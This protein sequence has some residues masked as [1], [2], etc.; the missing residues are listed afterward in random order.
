MT[1]TAQPFLSRK[2]HYS[3]RRPSAINLKPAPGRDCI[4]E[5][6][7]YRLRV[8]WTAPNVLPVPTVASLPRS[9]SLGAKRCTHKVD[10]LTDFAWIVHP[11]L[12]SALKLYC[13]YTG[14]FLDARAILNYM[15]RSCSRTSVRCYR[16]LDRRLLIP[17]AHDHFVYHTL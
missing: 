6:M 2:R 9:E 1:Y 13:V 17:S 16:L 5:G 14:P 15:I 4:F 10:L 11:S 8:P 7:K 12:R 3:P